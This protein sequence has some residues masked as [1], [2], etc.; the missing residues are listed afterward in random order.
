MAYYPKIY[1]LGS[2]TDELMKRSERPKTKP[3]SPAQIEK[4]RKEIEAK[5][6]KVKEEEEQKPLKEEPIQE[7]PE[8]TPS[9]KPFVFIGIPCYKTIHIRTMDSVV[10]T[11]L[12]H[13]TDFGFMSGVFV[14]ENQNKLV[15]MAREKKASHLFLIEHDMVF[16]PDTLEKL[17][18]LDKDVVAAPYSG[19]ALPRQPLVYDKKPNGE[20]YMM[21]YDIFLDKP[22]KVYG[23]P[24]GCTLI[25]MSVFDKIEKPYFFFEYDKKGKMLMSQDIYFSK[26]VNEAGLECWIE[27]RISINHIGEMD[28]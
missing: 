11:L 28:F 21:D 26:K 6:A 4:I 8:E 19:R 18:K 17:L 22:T 14:H 24:T 20:L 2:A 13:H 27:P 23:V 1:N 15:E 3:A 12:K 10:M 7:E 25:K 16:E 5:R 9:D